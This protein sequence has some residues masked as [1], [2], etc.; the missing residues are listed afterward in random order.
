MFGFKNTLRRNRSGARTRL[1]FDGICVRASGDRVLVVAPG[2][3]F[4]PGEQPDEFETAVDGTDAPPDVEQ[5][6]GFD[7]P[8]VS[9]GYRSE[10]ILP[11]VP[12][13]SLCGIVPAPRRA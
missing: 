10:Q 7:L 3:R 6:F 1:R 5:Y 2:L 9:L 8:C 12:R 4:R 13:S 11:A